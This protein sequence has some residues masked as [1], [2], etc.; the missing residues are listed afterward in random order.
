MGGGPPHWTLRR[1]LIA[2]DAWPRHLQP[3]PIL[4][5][6]GNDMTAHVGRNETRS[7]S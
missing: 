4:R 1:P 2:R 5:D 6:L 7:L 3:Q